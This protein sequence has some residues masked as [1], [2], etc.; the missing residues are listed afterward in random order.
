M[1]YPNDF[2]NKIIC[3]DCFEVMKG[4]PDNSVDL[5]VTSP[6]Y[7][8]GYYDKHKPHKS[9]VWRQRNIIYGNFKDNLKPYE[10]I[11]QQTMLL[12][13]L[14]RVLKPN[15]SIFYNHKVIIANHKAIFPEYVFNFNVRQIIIWSRKNTP[16]LAPIRFLPTT[17]YIYWIT[18]KNIQPKF[19]NKNLIFDSEIWEFSAKPTKNHPAPFPIELPKNCILA[20]T[21]KG[22]I[23]LDPYMGI[24]TTAIACKG[25]GR[26][27]IGIEINLEYCEIARRRVNATPEPLF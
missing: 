12:S 23:V 8:K 17:E 16:Q 15:G 5:V 21:A 22:D 10:Y 26:R 20:T 13:E 3:D 4:M 18:K 27:Y 14:C 9:D 2:I 1:K 19:Y 25:L 7:N 24:G 11:N 6:P